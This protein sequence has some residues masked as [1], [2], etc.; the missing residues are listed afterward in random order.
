MHA[1]RRQT[2]RGGKHAT[3]GK[4]SFPWVF[5]VGN[6]FARKYREANRERGGNETWT[7]LLSQV[8]D[9]YRSRKKI[10]QVDGY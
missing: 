1:T 9:V 3:C 4:F 2:F 5:G 7:G 8:D 10:L 6:V